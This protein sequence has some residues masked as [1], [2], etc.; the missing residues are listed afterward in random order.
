MEFLY[1]IYFCFF[2][3]LTK[4][5][6]NEVVNLNTNDI[7]NLNY[8]KKNCNMQYKIND[9]KC[10]DICVSETAAPHTRRFGGTFPGS[11]VEMGYVKYQYSKSQFIGPFGVTTIDFY[12]KP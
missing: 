6:N 3:K 1:L 7:L 12:T 5:L 11:C 2:V 4:Y 10:G 8:R 9:K